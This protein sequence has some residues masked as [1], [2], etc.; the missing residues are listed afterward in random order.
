MANKCRDCKRC[1]K[2]FFGNLI[3]AP[4]HIVGGAVGGLTV[5]L[6]RSHCPV[7]NHIMI[8]HKLVD[9]GDKRFQD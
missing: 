5:N 9:A 4:A 7:C 1:T 6:F 3:G 8:D 2:S